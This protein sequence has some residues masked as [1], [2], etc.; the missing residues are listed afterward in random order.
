MLSKTAYR[1][2]IPVYTADRISSLRPK[3]MVGGSLTASV[4]WQAMVYISENIL[5]GGF[6]GGAL[7]AEQWVLTAGRNLFVRKSP[8]HTRGKEPL[9]PKVYLGISKR[10]HANAS[11]EVAVEKVNIHAT[12]QIPNLLKLTLLNHNHHIFVYT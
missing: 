6:A 10:T 2:L 7:I 5:D 3:R 9:I 1:D 12:H 8:S 4:P 11:T